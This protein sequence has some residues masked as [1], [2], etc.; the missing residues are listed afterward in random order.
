ME[1]AHALLSQFWKDFPQV[2]ESMPSDCMPVVLNWKNGD[3][4]PSIENRKHEE[5][6]SDVG[7]IESHVRDAENTYSKWIRS[8]NTRT[9]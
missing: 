8:T 4:V 7:T 5:P 6:K 1:T 3:H 2:M 9:Y